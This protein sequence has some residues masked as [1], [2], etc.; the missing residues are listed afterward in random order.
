MHIH[1][2]S[3]NSTNVSYIN[4]M[5]GIHSKEFNNSIVK[6]IWQWCIE[7]QIW[8]TAVHIPGTKNVE[9]DRE[10]RV[11]SDNKEWITRP[12]IL[13]HIADI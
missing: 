1:T 2:Y 7:K 11:F 13:K 12:D 10:S 3:D 5:G 6:D 9:A 8:L 4:A